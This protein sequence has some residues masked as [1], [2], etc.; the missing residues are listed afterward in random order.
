MAIPKV[1]VAG[2]RLF[3]ADLNDNFQHVEGLAS[4]KEPSFSKNTAFNKDFGTAAE[5]VT[6]GND[7]RLAADRTRKVT[8]SSS[9]PSGGAEGDVWLRF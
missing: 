3:A 2:D 5:T 1:F 7:A 4:T 6:Q 8:I 9:A